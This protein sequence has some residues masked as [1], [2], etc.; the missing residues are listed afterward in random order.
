MIL[1]RRARTAPEFPLGAFLGVLS[2][3]MTL[4]KLSSSLTTGCVPKS[5]PAVAVA[6][7]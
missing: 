1:E 7:G 4:P 3:L 5:T 6:D 2:V